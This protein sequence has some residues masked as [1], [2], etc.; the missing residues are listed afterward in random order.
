VLNKAE[1]IDNGIGTPDWRLSLCLLLCWIIIFVVLVK[2]V[3]SSGKVAYFTALFPYVV[4]ITL[5]IR[6]CTLPGAGE[7]ILFFI[8]PDFNAI[9][10]ADV[11]MTV[12][13]TTIY[14]MKNIFLLK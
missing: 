11:I 2:G 14:S 5:L 6:G 1:N 13:F 4:L 8:T 7:G 9:L 12:H 10:S 3:A